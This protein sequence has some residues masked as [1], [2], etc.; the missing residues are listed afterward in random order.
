MVQHKPSAKVAV[1]YS[2]CIYCNE[3]TYTFTMSRIKEFPKHKKKKQGEPK[4]YNLNGK[5]H[6]VASSI[7]STFIMTSEIF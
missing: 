2:K 3:Y 5:D 6:L 4:F 7:L 1:S